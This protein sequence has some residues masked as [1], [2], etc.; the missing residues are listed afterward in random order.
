MEWYDR[1]NEHDISVLKALNENQVSF[2]I[3][4]GT[5]VAFYGCR[6]IHN[7]DDLDILIDPTIGNA[8]KFV[9]AVTDVARNAGR[10]LS[11]VIDPLD[12][13]K[14]K[15]QFPFKFTPFYCEFLTPANHVEFD[16][17]MSRAQIAKVG[18][19]EVHMVALSDLVAMKGDVVRDSQS[20]FEKHSNDLERLRAKLTKTAN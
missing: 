2:L 14:P 9:T 20:T 1:F 6:E 18:F 8:T 3:I 13:T 10:P 5:A 17:L 16:H 7:V 19:Q 4:G 15:V 11:K 12:M